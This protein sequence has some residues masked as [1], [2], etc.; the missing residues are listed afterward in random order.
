MKDENPHNELREGFP[1]LSSA[2]Q[3][4]REDAPEGYF[5]EMND[6]LLER[7]R[8][9]RDSKSSKRTFWYAAAAIAVLLI[10]YTATQLFVDSGPATGGKVEIQFAREEG[11]RWAEDYISE[12]ELIYLM[13]EEPLETTPAMEMEDQ[14]LEEYLLEEDIETALIIESL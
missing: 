2:K 1:R 6:R 5:E 8:E 10:T 3:N 12:D 9:E 11:L 13:P 7:I 14:E 4:L